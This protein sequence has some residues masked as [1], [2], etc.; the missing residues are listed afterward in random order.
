VFRH[1]DVDIV[2]RMI[3]VFH[4]RD[5][6]GDVVARHQGERDDA[7]RAVSEEVGAPIDAVHDVGPVDV[8]RVR[9]PVDVY[10]ERA[11]DADDPNWSMGAGLFETSPGRT[12]ISDAYRSKSLKSRAC[13]SSESAS[14]VALAD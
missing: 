6:P 10:V 8:R 9:V 5:D 7:E 3:D 2:F 4:H 12:T 14:D 1:D 13:P 11:V